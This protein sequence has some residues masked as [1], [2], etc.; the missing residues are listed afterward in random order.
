MS[1]ASFKRDTGQF[2][3][4]ISI[5][6]TTLSHTK[7]KDEIFLAVALVGLGMTI[8]SLLTRYKAKYKVP[9]VWK[10]SQGK[11]AFSSTN[12]PTAGATFT[13]PL[14]R[15]KHALQLYSLGTPNGVK[16]T[17]LLE[18]LI[19]IYG[20]AVE[21]DAFLINIY[22]GDQ[23]SSGFVKA[24]PNSKIPVLVHYEN[25]V[26]PPKITRVFETSAIMLYLCEKF[27]TKHV[28]LPAVGDPLRAECLSWLMFT[29]GSAPYLG[30]GFG[31]F[32]S[33]AEEKIPYAI[34]RYSM[35]T[36]RQLD[37]LDKHLSPSGAGAPY[38]CGAKL[39]IADF[40]CWAWYGSLV[41]GRLYTGSDQF[42]QVK[43]YLHV[44]LWA[45]RLDA[46]KGVRRGRKVNRSWGE[47]HMKL[48][49]R[50]SVSDLEALEKQEESLTK[51]E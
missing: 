4:S 3:C 32:F 28:F 6:S 23:F 39:T 24:N 27:D 12:R 36:K 25:G 19:L 47:S 35:E 16:V 38:L 34:N 9:K 17:T 41:L 15:G 29:H 7:I 21:Y 51:P 44:L 33:Y 8:G 26:E 20:P 42:L 46:R 13:K 31:H 5:M 49:E 45:K 50:H 18:E 30:G 14:P 10:E 43:D 11:S 40:A 48:L 2:R 37:V 1:L 22:Q